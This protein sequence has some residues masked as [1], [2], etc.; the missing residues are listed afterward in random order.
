LD[1]F[2]HAD[3]DVSLDGDDRLSIAIADVMLA[4]WSGISAGEAG[5]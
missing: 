1:D 3:H 5:F 2:D 4:Y